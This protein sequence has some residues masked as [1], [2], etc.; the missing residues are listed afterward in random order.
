MTETKRTLHFKIPRFLKKLFQ[1]LKKDLGLFRKDLELLRKDSGV[2]QKDSGV[3]RKYFFM[4]YFPF[5]CLYRMDCEFVMWT[6]VKWLIISYVSSFFRTT[7]PR[8]TYMR[9]R[10]Q[11]YTDMEHILLYISTLL[12]CKTDKLIL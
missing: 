10:S 7:G 3:F 11:L 12:I 5:L 4:F 2:L 1:L 9:F 6:V 8:L